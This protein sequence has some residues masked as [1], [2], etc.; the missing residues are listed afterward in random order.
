M[1]IGEINKHTELDVH[2]KEEK[3][4]R[5]IIGFDLIW[6]NGKTVPH[7]TKKQIQELKAILDII[8]EDMFK[9]VDLNN[10]E[11]RERAIHIVRETEKIKESIEPPICITKEKADSLIQQVAW[12]LPELN[13]FL[14]EDGKPAFPFYDWLSEG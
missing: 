10:T 12:N 3:K 6:S 5:A 9:F 11:N 13:R 4:G 1:C 14:E 8:F 2:Y 7:A